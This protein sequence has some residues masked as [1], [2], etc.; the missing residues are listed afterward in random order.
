MDKRIAR[1][2]LKL[3]AIPLHYI[4]AGVLPERIHNAY[5]EP[6]NLQ[7]RHRSLL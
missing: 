7:R 5:K 6:G 4:R 3:F 1:V 2:L